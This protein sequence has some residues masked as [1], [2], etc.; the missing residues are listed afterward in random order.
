M[1]T[2]IILRVL[3]MKKV[4]A[5][6][7]TFAIFWPAVSYAKSAEEER[8]IQN[9]SSSKKGETV[10]WYNFNDGMKLAKGKRKPV[11]MDFYADWCGWCRKMDAEVFSDPEVAAKLKN[12]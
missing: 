3:T 8:Q 5:F 11:V 1:Y 7:M 4:Y 6:I 10:I 2:R 12:N 9:P